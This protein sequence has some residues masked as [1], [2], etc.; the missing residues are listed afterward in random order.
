M[1]CKNG[2]C[3]IDVN[4]HPKKGLDKNRKYPIIVVSKPDREKK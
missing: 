1:E 3:S 4:F 2:V